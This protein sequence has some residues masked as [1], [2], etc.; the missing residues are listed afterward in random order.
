MRVT[1][2]PYVTGRPTDPYMGTPTGDRLER[3]LPGEPQLGDGLPALLPGYGRMTVRH[4]E[5]V[6]DG[7]SLA[8][9]VEVTCREIKPATVEE[10]VAASKPGPKRAKPSRP[11]CLYCLEAGEGDDRHRTVDCPH[12]PDVPRGVL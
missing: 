11:V 4:R 3:D 12:K 8:L 2:V 7:A 6:E 10:P 9:V 5:W 1:I